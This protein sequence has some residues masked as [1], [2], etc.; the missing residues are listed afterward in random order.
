MSQKERNE[1]DTRYQ[2]NLTDLY[3]T[4]DDW[5]NDLTS[6]NLES[7]KFLSFKGK[8]GA[9]A[10]NLLDYFTFNS[11]FSKRLARVA[12]YV[13]LLSDED[14]RNADNNALYKEVEQLYVDLSQLTDF[15]SSELAAIEKETFEKFAKENFVVE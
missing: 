14:L 2:W 3:P 8:L 5:R 6:L 13:S 7:K 4:L 1:I 11:D 12:I 9:S 10:T 15:V